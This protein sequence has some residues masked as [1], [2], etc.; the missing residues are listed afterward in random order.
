MEWEKLQFVMVNKEL[1]YSYSCSYEL[2]EELVIGWLDDR[3]RFCEA[4][5]AS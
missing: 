3:M 4:E 2:L 5:A 1:I